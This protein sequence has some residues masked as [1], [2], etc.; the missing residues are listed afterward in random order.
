[1]LATRLYSFSQ[2]AFYKDKWTDLAASSALHE[3]GLQV[4]GGELESKGT[5]T[6][7]AQSRYPGAGESASDSL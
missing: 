4:T 2:R 1:M 7:P 6:P 3:E 5:A